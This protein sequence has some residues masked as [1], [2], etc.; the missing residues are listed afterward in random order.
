MRQSQGALHCDYR[1]HY[2]PAKPNTSGL[3]L[4]YGMPDEGWMCSCPAGKVRLGI[5]CVDD[6]R[7]CRI[8]KQYEKSGWP[9]Y[10]YKKRK[11]IPTLKE[12]T[13]RD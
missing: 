2:S 6:E 12:V 13:G 5:N 11:A 7:K 1:T 3:L 9:S 8:A 10:M 4:N